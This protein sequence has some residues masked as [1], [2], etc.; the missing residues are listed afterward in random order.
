MEASDKKPFDQYAILE[1][2]GK[3][4]L[5]GRVLEEQVFG[6]SMIRLDIPKDKD[7]KEYHTRYFHPNALYGITPVSKEVAYSVAEYHDV[8]PAQS[9]ELR[10]LT[11]AA[12]HADADGEAYDADADF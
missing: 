6:I 11:A 2:M 9:W 10:Q 5:G 12:P 3:L 4:R 8:P 1:L 7:F